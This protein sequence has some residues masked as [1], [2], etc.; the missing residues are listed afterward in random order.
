MT[1]WASQRAD[2]SGISEVRQTCSFNCGSRCLLRLQVRDGKILWVETDNGEE[3][4]EF[5]GC[6]PACA[7][8]HCVIGSIVPS[9]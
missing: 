5:R 4:S 8:G 1:R 3:A 6:A 7:G 2:R 9:A